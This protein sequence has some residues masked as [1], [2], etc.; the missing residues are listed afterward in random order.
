MKL[1]RI[2][3]NPDHNGSVKGTPVGVVIDFPQWPNENAP[4]APEA[5]AA[6]YH[7]KPEDTEP[8]SPWVCEVGNPVHLA[9]LLGTPEGFRIYDDGKAHKVPASLPEPPK[10]GTVVTTAAPLAPLSV[11]AAAVD[12]A[13]VESIRALPVRELK[14]TLNT[15]SDA[16][17]KAALDAEN[18]QQ[19]PRKG[20]VQTIEAH[21]ATPAA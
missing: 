4:T 6:R 2:L 3:I 10:V 1:E 9:R 13:K 11:Q 17:L 14:A 15:F 18:E 7:F 12:A 19:E 8:G 16:E 20:F 21:L 5:P